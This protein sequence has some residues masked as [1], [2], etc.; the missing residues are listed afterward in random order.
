M[1]PESPRPLVL[2]IAG[3]GLEV[4]AAEPGIRLAT[5]AAHTPFLAP[6]AGQDCAS[7]VLA[8]I[9]TTRPPR[10]T[11]RTIFDTGAVWRLEDLGDGHLLT[12]R[13]PLYGS[14]PY[15]AVEFDERF[16][17]GRGETL[18]GGPHL[19]EGTMHPFVYPFDEVVF[20][21]RLSRNRG[22]LV[23]ACG[24]SHGGRGI[25][26]LGTSGAGKSTSAR[27]WGQKAS[28]I[29]LSDD[30]IVI[31]SEREGY[32]I[33]GTP[34]HGEA[35]CESPGS[36]KLDAVFILEQ[37]PR[38]RIIDLHPAA[39]VAQMMVRAFPAMWDQSGLEFA[40]RFLSRMAERV[41]VRKLQFLPELS[42][43]DCVLDAL[44]RDG[45]RPSG[46]RG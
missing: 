10:R 7:I 13:S 35:G 33:Y 34:W 16:E 4:R 45:A 37:A 9:T 31:R 8:P 23:H 25:L 36:V 19:L 12:L 14:N 3:I 2:E 27:L 18:D 40:V 30:R 46:E 41:P 22:V 1:A 39:A 44:D 5:D 42:A 28:S 26:L 6:G 17:A 21:A 11:G 20:L 32:R 15:L 24:L 38:N 29:I 43:V